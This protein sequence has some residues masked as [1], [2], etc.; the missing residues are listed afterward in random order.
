MIAYNKITK[1]KKTIMEKFG[2][3]EDSR[4]ETLNS[5]LHEF[6]GEDSKVLVIT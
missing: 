2:A 3:K 5:G 6:Y 4:I 1:L